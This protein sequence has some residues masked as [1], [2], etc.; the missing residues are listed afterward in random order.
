MPSTNWQIWVDTGG[1]FTDCLALAPNGH[2]H[3][4]KILS[5]STLRGSI[6]QIRDDKTVVVAAKWLNGAPDLL[7]GYAFRLLQQPHPP[8]T[9]VGTDSAR[10]L[11]FLSE[12][13]E[14]MA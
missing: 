8:I 12:L 1:T 13:P 7:A 4:A 9:V 6:L 14:H 10:G 5:N 11:L 3:R 2:L